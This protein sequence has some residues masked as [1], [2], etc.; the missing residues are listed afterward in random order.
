MLAYI[1]LL[2]YNRG[3]LGSV[4]MIFVIAVGIV[5][6]FVVVDDDDDCICQLVFH[7]P[8]CRQKS[9]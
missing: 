1:C 7:T 9:L 8:E 4:Y 2:T 5:V 6:V 3:Y